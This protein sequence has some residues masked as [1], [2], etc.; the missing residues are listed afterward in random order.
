MRQRSLDIDKSP[1]SI[2][3]LPAGPWS[4]DEE[5]TRVFGDMLRRSIPDYEGMRRIVVEV[6]RPFVRPGTDVVDLGCS[7]GDGIAAFVDPSVRCVGV[8]VSEPMLAA[9]RQRFARELGTGL[10]ELHGLDLRDSYPEVRASL[11]L[12][13]LTLQFTPVEDRQRILAAA[14]EHAVEGGGLV[15]VEKVA[16]GSPRLEELLRGLH[17]ARKL[18][19]GYTREEVDRKRMSLAGVLVPLPAVENE[20]LLRQAGWGEV[21]CVWRSLNFA[22]W[23]AVATPGRPHDEGH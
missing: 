14:R 20:R 13:V 8:E 21:E 6:G 11:T 2:G 12:L 22:A 3:H 7:R 1:S 9:A 18:A 19:N 5:V 4:F 15:L 16:G 23:L 10:V 17:E